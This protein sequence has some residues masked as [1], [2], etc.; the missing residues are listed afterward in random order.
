MQEQRRFTE[1]NQFAREMDHFAQAI[2][3]GQEPHT[4]GAEGLADMRVI[5][6]IYRAAQGG[7]VVKLI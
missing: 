2:R 1:Q 4:P 6:A 3:A 7:S 5:E